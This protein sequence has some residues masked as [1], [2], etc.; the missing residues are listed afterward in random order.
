MRR[1]LAC[2]A[3]GSEIIGSWSESSWPGAAGTFSSGV[4][5]GAIAVDVT[6]MSPG[7]RVRVGERFGPEEK[8]QASR[9][10]ASKRTMENRFFM[11]VS[12][13]EEWRYRFE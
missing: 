6:I 11:V 13:L 8:R 4:G 2:P 5:V 9:R 10:S 7:W 3:L 1:N 12:F